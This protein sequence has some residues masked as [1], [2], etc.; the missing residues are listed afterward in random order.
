MTATL[1]PPGHLA[2]ASRLAPHAPRCDCARCRCEAGLQLLRDGRPDMA[3]RVLE[4]LPD[5]ITDEAGMAFAK[6]HR[7][8]QLG[9]G[10]GPP[11]PKPRADAH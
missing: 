7:A 3:W 8:A 9:R 10:S 11:P 4:T 5:Q 1:A 6:G 2:T